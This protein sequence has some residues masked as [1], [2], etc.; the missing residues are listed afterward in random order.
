VLALEELGIP[1][2]NVS[3]IEFKGAANAQCKALGLPQ[4]E[5]VWVPHP[6]QPKLPEEVRALADN[7][8]EQVVAK[9][10]DHRIQKAA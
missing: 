4:Y 9:L 3:T 10:L 1:T 5:P 2:A 6:V 8:V 7:V